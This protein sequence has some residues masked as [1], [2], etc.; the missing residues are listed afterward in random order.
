MIL[1]LG[2]IPGIMFVTITRRV[3]I[4]DRELLFPESVAAAEI[5]KA[6]QKGAGG[7]YYS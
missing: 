3:L 6:G 2:G 1:V 5:H 7:K 4:G